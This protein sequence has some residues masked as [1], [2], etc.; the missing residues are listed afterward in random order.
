M[1]QLVGRKLIRTDRVQGIGPRLALSPPRVCSPLISKTLF[2]VANAWSQKRKIGRRSDHQHRLICCVSLHRAPWSVCRLKSL[3]CCLERGH[4]YEVGSMHMRVS[5]IVPGPI[6]TPV[7]DNALTLEQK[8][9]YAK[10]V[11]IR[12]IRKPPHHGNSKAFTASDATGFIAGVTLP[13]A[14]GRNIKVSQA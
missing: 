5:A 7:T 9:A 13:V 8:G 3:D 4:G 6:D 10:T 1:V 14:S 11:P 2:C 12:C